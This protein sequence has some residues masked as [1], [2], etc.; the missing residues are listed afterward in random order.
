[1]A[2]PAHVVLT[3][4]TGENESLAELLAEEVA[5]VSVRPLIN[6]SA[7]PITNQLKKPALD[8]DHYD[9]IIFVSKTAVR[10]G[11]ELL[12]QYWPQWPGSLTW[13]AVGPGTA[14]ALADYEVRASYPEQPGSEGLL[15]MPELIAPADSRILIV[16]GTG[17]RELLGEELKNRNAMVEYWEVY[18]RN[19]ITHSDWSDVLGDSGKNI[20]VLTSGEIMDHFRNQATPWLTSCIAVVSSRRGAD[21]AA[22]YPF[23]DVINAGGASE[24]ALYDA[25]VGA[26]R[27]DSESV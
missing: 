2:S 8:L 7:L 14:Q 5:K 1:M 21:A 23:K 22:F 12:E 17:G 4:P 25:V 6:L 9:K 10:C 13:L 16:R 19:E 18:T 15:D 27:D 24:Q 20:V 26:T 11:L 3:R